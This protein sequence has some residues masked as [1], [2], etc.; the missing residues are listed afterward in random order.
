MR[1]MGSLPGLRYK[2]SWL[3]GPRTE[4]DFLVGAV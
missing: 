1:P 3:A 2:N 4:L